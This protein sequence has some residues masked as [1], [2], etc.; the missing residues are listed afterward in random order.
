MI[1]FSIDVKNMLLRDICDKIEEICVDVFDEKPLKKIPLKDR[2]I[3]YPKGHSIIE[4]LTGHPEQDIRI[5]VIIIDYDHATVKLVNTEKLVKKYG[6]TSF[7]CGITR[8]YFYKLREKLIKSF[9]DE[10]GYIKIN[11][12]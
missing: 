2:N 6:V 1:I 5:E 12:R 11:G 4:A 3:Y 10:N 8:N 7:R 9:T